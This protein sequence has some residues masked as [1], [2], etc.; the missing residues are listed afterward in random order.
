MIAN[1]VDETRFVIGWMSVKKKSD[2]ELRVVKLS[3]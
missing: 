2:V 1:T 3:Q